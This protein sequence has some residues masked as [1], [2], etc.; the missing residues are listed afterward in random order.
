M[1]LI[2]DG[3]AGLAAFLKNRTI[4]RATIETPNSHESVDDI[5][6]EYADGIKTYIEGSELFFETPQ[7]KASFEILENA[8]IFINKMEKATIV[9]TFAGNGRLQIECGN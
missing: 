6:I 8:G 3:A 7:V 9:A 4:L 5:T 2:E 1:E